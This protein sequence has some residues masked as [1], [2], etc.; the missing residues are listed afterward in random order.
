MVTNTHDT[1]V[2]G[3]GSLRGEILAAQNGDTIQFASKLKGSTIILSSDTE[4][5]ISNNIT[6]HGPGQNI[7]AVEAGFY[8]FKGNP[9]AAQSR[10]FEIAAGATVS[11]NDLTLE[12]GSA[13]DSGGGILNHGSLTLEKD[14]IKGCVANQGGGVFDDSGA[15]VV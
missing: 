14:V 12:N 8:S 10:L 3:D 7:L 6:I 1:G 4:I 5:L 9:H 11:I 13:P 15:S 2:V